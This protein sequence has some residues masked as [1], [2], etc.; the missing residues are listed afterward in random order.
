MKNLIIL[1]ALINLIACASTKRPNWVSQPRPEC[2]VS[3]AT[4]YSEGHARN[5]ATMKNHRSI[6]EGYYTEKMDDGRYKVL[7]LACDPTR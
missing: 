5:S 2:A 4:A 1:I 3:I 6:I 7:V